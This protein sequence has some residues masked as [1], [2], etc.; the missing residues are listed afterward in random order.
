MMSQR[1]GRTVIP[2]MCRR[3]FG[4]P[5]IGNFARV[6]KRFACAAVRNPQP[7]KARRVS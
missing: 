7:I 6:A 4:L 3:R 5:I 2:D 1:M